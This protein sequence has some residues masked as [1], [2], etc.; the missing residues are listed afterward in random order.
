MGTPTLAVH[1]PRVTV[2]NDPEIS[3]LPDPVLVVED[4]PLHARL[5]RIA[6]SAL[7]DRPIE[8]FCDGS[9]AAARLA[10]ASLPV[11]VLMVFDL[12]VPGRDG[13]ALLKSCASDPRLVS[14]PR[15]I[16]T[17]S[18]LTA[19]RER[20]LAAGAVLYEEKPSDSEGFVS[21]AARLAA[22]IA[23]PET[24]RPSFGSG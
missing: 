12:D 24:G 16:V 2:R 13:H 3:D 1:A 9:L 14:V 10:D 22:L 20:C 23:S 4:H 18:G 19:D 7:L 21:L 8:V 15:A 11:P 17:S 6:L 5:L